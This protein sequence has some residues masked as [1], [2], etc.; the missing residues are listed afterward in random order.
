MSEE[1]ILDF[2]AHYIGCP[3]FKGQRSAAACILFDRYKVCRRRCKSL[4]SH[5]KKEPDLVEKVKE[6]LEG[7][8]EKKQTKSLLNGLKSFK[9]FGKNLPNNNLNCKYCNFVASSE[10]GL[11]THLKRTHKK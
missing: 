1:L 6:Y 9:F 10:R 4:E 2:K 11:K 5:L 3:R 7:R 8:K